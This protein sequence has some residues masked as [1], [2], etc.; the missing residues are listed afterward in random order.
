MT[1]GKDTRKAKNETSPAEW[2]I[3]VVSA[4]LVLGAIGSLLYQALADKEDPPRVEIQVN[5]I[6]PSGDNYLVQ[7]SVQNQATGTA[8]ALVIEGTLE[9]DTG[10]VETSQVTIDYL[11]GNGRREAGIF[12]TRD[13]R[14]FT[15]RL[16]PVGYDLP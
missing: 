11:P 8:E 15:L 3:A 1:N 13:P 7:V 16:R 5:S 10:S 2:I 14:L 6:Q 12:F 9:A 4:L